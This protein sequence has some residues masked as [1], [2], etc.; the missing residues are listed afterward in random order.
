MDLWGRLSNPPEILK[1][2]SDQGW[3]GPARP[4]CAATGATEGPDSDP[5][6][7]SPEQK[8]RLS[9]PVQRRLSE[10]ETDELIFSYG[11]GE[12]IDALARRYELHRTTVIHHLDRA[13]I[14]RR[15][16][17]R[18]MTDDSVDRAAARYGGGASL[19]TVGQEF[20]VHER[21]LARE[22]RR[23]GVSIRPRLG[24]QPQP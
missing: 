12:S 1:Q 24:W 9:N 19:A 14:A 11:E 7:G 22:F 17:V 13:G 15:R 8:G 23:S 3:S 10:T 5:V 4:R 16:V 2:L 21:T 20:G 18:K 6:T